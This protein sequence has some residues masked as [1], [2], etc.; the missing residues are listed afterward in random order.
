[1]SDRKIFKIP[2]DN[3]ILKKDIIERKVDYMMHIYECFKV[4]TRSNIP[5]KINIFSFADTNLEVII[6]KESYIINIK[7]LI[8]YFADIEEYEI[9]TVLSNKLEA[10][11]K[12]SDSKDL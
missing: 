9:C 5:R 11:N 1:M 10:L 2:K 7:N 12:N 6:K 8:Q 3:R 4:I